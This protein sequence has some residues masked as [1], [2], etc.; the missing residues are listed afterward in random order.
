VDLLFLWI[1]PIVLALVPALVRLWRGRALARRLD[2][3]ALPERLLKGRQPQVAL[4][5]ATITVLAMVWP[6]RL[7]ATV[8]ILILANFAASYPLR[9]ALYNE[10]WSIAVFLWFFVRL[11]VVIWGFWILLLV[12]PVATNLAGWQGWTAAA[13]AV[14]II[15]AWNQHFGDILRHVLGTRPVESADL[16]ARFAALVERSSVRAPRFDRIPLHGGVVANALAVPSLRQPGV[17]FSETLLERLSAGELAAICAHELAHLEYFNPPRLRRM[18]LVSMTFILAGAVMAPALRAMGQELTLLVMGG[19]ALALFT[20]LMALGL[21][22]QKNETASDLRAIEMG[23]DPEALIAAL[24]KLHA[25][26]RLPRRWD[27][28]MEQSATHPSLARRVRDI[29]A[30]AGTA[31]LVLGESATVAGTGDAL[32]SVTFHSDR[33][34]WT[35]GELASFTMPYEALIE[36]RVDAA[37]RDKAARLIAADARGRRWELGLATADVARV[38]RVLDIV[39]ARLRPFSAA[40]SE[41]PIVRLVAGLAAA[42]ALFAGQPAALVAVFGFFDAAF[43]IAAMS[44]VASLSAGV[45]IWRD[46]AAR[47]I[48]DN[49]I[50]PLPVLLLCGAFLIS[51]AWRS[52]DAT[53]SAS[54]WRLSFMAGVWCA[55]CLVPIAAGSADL[56]GLHLAARS[57]SGFSILAFAFAVST[58]ARPARWARPAAA[59]AVAAG[60]AVL[61]IG[62]AVFLDV[63]V[64]DPLLLPAPAA[65]E[66]VPDASVV[67]ADFTVAVS[68]ADLRL[69]TDGRSIIVIEDLDE[70]QRQFHVGRVGGTLEAFDADDA[71]FAG[72]DDVI[73]VRNGDK[74]TLI[75]RIPV[76]A[77]AA[78]AWERQ[79]DVVEHPELSLNEGAGSWRVVGRESNRVI[80]SVEGSVESGAVSRKER[81]PV[82]EMEGFKAA[83]SGDRLLRVEDRYMPGRLNESWYALGPILGQFRFK[84]SL[85]IAGPSGRTTLASSGFDADCR[86]VVYGDGAV[87]TVFDGSRTHVL[88]VELPSGAI[89]AVARMPGWFYASQAGRGWIGGVLD[90]GDVAAVHLATGS[91]LRVPREQGTFGNIVSGSGDR[92]VMASSNP[93]DVR[94]RILRIQP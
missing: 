69:S 24:E 67:E 26:A 62:S 23:G 76:A 80:V 6:G 61:A 39:D 14:V 58:L 59:A 85:S 28:R 4:D 49:A 66:L 88:V 34:V 94:V 55:L 60:I 83:A 87:C 54:S 63:A 13:A 90:R 15:A 51:F 56:V 37:G 10:T 50:W 7:A 42:V 91:I 57:W 52:R 77:P 3:P 25:Y 48:G 31:P 92:V 22:R 32:A 82:G 53:V 43:P 68:P 46:G 79:L 70:D 78:G 2:D 40:P 11:T 12:A 64:R 93:D 44:G 1:A 75:R 86:P 29:R 84:T 65:R 74:G 18:R 19:W 36:L 9:R 73:A 21:T 8:P 41:A 38:Q 16:L 72:N 47:L 35:E 17:V 81:W 30:A 89:R 33:L 5:A 27:Q 45:L 71:W 20:Y